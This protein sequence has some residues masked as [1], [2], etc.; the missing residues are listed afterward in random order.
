M[1]YLASMLV[2]PS[3]SYELWKPGLAFLVEPVAIHQINF[4]LPQIAKISRFRNFRGKKRENTI[5]RRKRRGKKH[6]K[7][8]ILDFLRKLANLDI[9]FS[10]IVPRFFPGSCPVLARFLPGSCPVLPGS[11]RFSPVLP[12]SRLV[13][14]GIFQFLGVFSS[15]FCWGQ[16]KSQKIRKF[17]IGRRKSAKFRNFRSECEES[18]NSERC[19]NFSGLGQQNPENSCP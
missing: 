13:F 3:L 11:A 7:L 8:K 16:R 1:E 12:G 4:T 15:V 10:K 2:F 6:K 19:T 18:Q 9:F 17:S 14:W 5:F